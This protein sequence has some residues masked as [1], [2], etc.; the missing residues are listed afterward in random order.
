MFVER[1]ILREKK[2]QF[3]CKGVIR[4][5]N[6]F[7]DRL[8]KCN[9]DSTGNQTLITEWVNVLFIYVHL[10]LTDEGGEQFSLFSS[11][12]SEVIPEISQ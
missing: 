4:V 6:R 12:W 5:N 3:Q 11:E 2:F 1:F 10:H 8:H 7:M 9:A